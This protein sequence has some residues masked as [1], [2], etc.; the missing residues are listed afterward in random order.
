[1][2]LLCE[3]QDT[4]VTPSGRWCVLTLFPQPINSGKA[5]TVPS[6]LTVLYSLAMRAGKDRPLGDV[7]QNATNWNA[8]ILVAASAGAP[9][10]CACRAVHAVDSVDRRC[11]QP[12]SRHTKCSKANR[13]T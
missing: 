4:R 5:C 8:F 6:V 3:Y 2:K 9:R 12:D 13:A 7:L 11:M 10:R 1:M